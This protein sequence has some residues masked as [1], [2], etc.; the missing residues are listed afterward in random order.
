MRS[1]VNQPDPTFPRSPGIIYETRG[2]DFTLDRRFVL[3][4]NC[5]HHSRIFISAHDLICTGCPPKSGGEEVVDNEKT[6]MRTMIFS[7]FTEELFT[8]FPAGKSRGEQ[9]PKEINA[10]T[11]RRGA[12]NSKPSQK[13]FALFAPLRLCVKNSPAQPR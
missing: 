4:M 8:G 13:Y 1:R 6:S 3:S 7:I 12:G 10:K 9:V 11:Q 5:G 2:F